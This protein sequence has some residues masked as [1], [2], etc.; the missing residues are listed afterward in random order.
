MISIEDFSNQWG[1]SYSALLQQCVFKNL[2]P[3]IGKTKLVD[4]TNIIYNE[5]PKCNLIN[6]GIKWIWIHVPK[7]ELKVWVLFF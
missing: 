2:D 1:L 7:Y 3:R 6:Y 5:N 4:D